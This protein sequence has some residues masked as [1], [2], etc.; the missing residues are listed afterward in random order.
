MISKNFK[1]NQKNSK[2]SKISIFFRR[3]T[4]GTHNFFYNQ[5]ILGFFYRSTRNFIADSM[6]PPK[7]ADFTEEK[8]ILH[9]EF[10]GPL[11]QETILNINEF[12]EITLKYPN[13]QPLSIL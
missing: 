12:R 11:T 5:R 4:L 8:V 3:P 9:S 7:R 13:L 2:F 1:K 10:F 6:I